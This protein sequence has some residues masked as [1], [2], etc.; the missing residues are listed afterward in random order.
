MTIS[1]PFLDVGA[2][3]RQIKQE[4][5][6]AVSR[7]LSSGWYLLGN[8]LR[9]F[10]EEFAQYVG[11]KHC[12]GVANGLDALTLSLRAMDI[13]P[14]DEVIVPANTYIATWLAVSQVQAIPIP[15]EPDPLTYN[16]NP[17]HIEMAISPKTKAILPVH[18]YGQPA[19][20]D[21]II[22]LAKKYHLYILE[23]SAQAHGAKY[24]GQRVGGLGTASGWSFYPGKNLGA[25]GDGGAVTTNDDFI[26][27]KVRMLRNYGS[28]IK[29]VN[30]VQG[31]NSRL[32][33]L[34]AAV[35]RVKLKHLDTW[36]KRRADIAKKYREQITN[37][38]IKQPIVPDWAD[39]VWHL[40]VV[41]HS[42]RDLLKKR[43]SDNGIETIIHYPIPPH[44]Q[45]AYFSSNLSNAFPLTNQLSEE[46]LSLPIGPHLREEQCQH[47]I[48]T[49]NQS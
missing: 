38:H 26:A 15:V 10:E 18:L 17:E 5:D 41:R 28:K 21:P 33:E 39:P 44:K 3:Y 4:I 29:Y 46:I 19:R 47:L 23:D 9:A 22:A 34:Q 40:F 36:N 31:V 32:D 7:T 12:I 35:L 13:G 11:T 45:K 30:D 43:L 6:E 42:C 1:V 25:F 49:L 8:E 27:E 2:T 16:I 24:K 14:G 20:M 37:K 48:D